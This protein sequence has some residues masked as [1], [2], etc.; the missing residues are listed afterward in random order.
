MPILRPFLSLCLA[1]LIALTSVQMAQARGQA[2]PV[3]IMVLCIGTETRTVSVDA[4]GQP[5]EAPHLCP[6]CVMALMAALPDAATL[7]P[8]SMALR[9]VWYDTEHAAVA[10]PPET[11]ATARGPP[12]SI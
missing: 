11:Q 6:D 4:N 8:V 9:G 12:L 5:V 3:G 1:C 7:P 10:D 2:R